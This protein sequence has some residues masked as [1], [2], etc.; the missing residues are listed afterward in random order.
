M[1]YQVNSSHYVDISYDTKERFISYWHQIFEIRSMAPQ[2]ILEIGIGNG[3]VAQYMKR[4]N[5]NITTVDIDMHLNPDIVASV[6]AMPFQSNI[7]DLVACF[8]VLEHLPFEY[9]ILSLKEIYRLSKCHVVLSLPDV[10]RV[11]PVYIKIPKL[12]EIKKLIS[13]FRIRKLKHEFN[14]EHYWEIGKGDYPL[15]RILKIIREVK[16]NISYTYRIFE[17]PYHRLFILTK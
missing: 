8:E 3:F 13:L 9:F 7:F 11:Y 17:N 5:Y 2:T 15:K 16:F 14:G 12:G 10:Q 1:K 4:L 6:S